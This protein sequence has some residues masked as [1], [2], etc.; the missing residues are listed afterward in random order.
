[1]M[2]Q[3]A[4]PGGNI[5]N[6]PP[7]TVAS[8]S[9][10]DIVSD[11]MNEENEARE[12][13]GGS[14]LTLRHEPDAYSLLSPFTCNWIKSQSMQVNIPVAEWSRVLTHNLEVLGSNLAQGGS[15]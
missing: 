1:M 15:F 11:L 13:M 12:Y 10:P 9:S 8:V 6:L 4:A 3:T 14:N 2:G 7:V 5:L